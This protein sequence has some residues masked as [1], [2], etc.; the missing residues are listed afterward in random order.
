MSIPDVILKRT[1]RIE[2]LGR[3]FDTSAFEEEIEAKQDE[4]LRKHGLPV[5]VT[6]AH[7]LIGKTIQS[8]EDIS[9]SD[10]WSD[11]EIIFTDNT[12]LEFS[13]SEEGE[14][15]PVHIFREW[16]MPEKLLDEYI[17]FLENLFSRWKEILK[18]KQLDK[19]RKK[20]EEAKLELEKLE[21]E[22]RK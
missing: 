19:A 20:M 11:A 5:P 9:E 10:G 18:Q 21:K 7:E 8:I 16:E 6:E 22:K 4:L 2:E 14:L 15:E 1:N 12:K 3:Q 17:I 13:C